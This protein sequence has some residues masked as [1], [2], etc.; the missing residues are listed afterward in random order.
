[1]LQLC[2]LRVGPSWA[3][4]RLAKQGGATP[5]NAERPGVEAGDVEWGV[6]D[7]GHQVQTL[8]KNSRG[9]QAVG[10]RPRVGEF[11]VGVGGVHRSLQP[12]Y[13]LRREQSLSV[14]GGRRVTR[15]KAPKLLPGSLVAR[16]NLVRARCGGGS[17]TH[18]VLILWRLV[19]GNADKLPAGLRPGFQ[20][21]DLCPHPAFE[22]R[23]HDAPTS[24][25]VV[26]ITP[27]R[28]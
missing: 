17:L 9:W 6:S 28:L 22:Q 18:R 10:C 4:G 1:M 11:V 23:V 26:C 16:C 13:E 8:A 25:E 19:S 20:G 2:R 24:A 7:A 14:A 21:F 12:G 5:I 27:P 3:V 15:M